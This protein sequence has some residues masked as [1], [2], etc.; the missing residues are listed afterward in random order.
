MSLFLL[1]W[2]EGGGEEKRKRKE[3]QLPSSATSWIL[4]WIIP[5]KSLG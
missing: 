4:I 1:A 2:Q 5:Y 3:N